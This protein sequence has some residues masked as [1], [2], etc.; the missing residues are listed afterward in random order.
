MQYHGI[1]IQSSQVTCRACIPLAEEHVGNEADSNECH[2]AA[3]ASLFAIY[4]KIKHIMH[5]SQGIL[6]T[7]FKSRVTEGPPKYPIRTTCFR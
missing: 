1:N 5:H 6:S 7:S 3:W 4:L 2:A